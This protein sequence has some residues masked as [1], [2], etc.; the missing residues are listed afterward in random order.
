MGHSADHEGG[1][2]KHDKP[3]R[4]TTIL[5][6]N[7]P[8]VMSDDHATGAEIKR[9]AGIP[10]DFKLYDEK[11]KEV[12]DHKNVKLNEGERFTAISGQDVS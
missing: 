12:G 7:R 1:R 6:N 2:D 10:K 8:V 11:G 5:V 4:Q 3:S 9:A